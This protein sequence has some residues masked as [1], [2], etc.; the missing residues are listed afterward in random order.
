MPGP[1][2]T[3]PGS[4]TVGQSGHTTD[5]NEIT[6]ALTQASKLFTPWYNVIFYG[7]DPTGSADSTSAFAAAMTA[8]G[9]SP[10]TIYVPAGTYKTSSV[11]SFVLDQNM[12][13]D[14]SSVT[15]INYTGSTNAIVIDNSGTFNDSFNAGKFTGFSL[16]GSTATGTPVG[17]KFGNLQGVVIHDVGIY[18]FAGKGI[19]GLNHSGGWS[20][21]NNIQAILVGNG[22]AA[23][24]DTSS[25]DY[26]NIDLL[27]VTSPGA[28]GMYLQNSA[29]MQGC[30]IRIR[31]NF[32]VASSNTAAVIGIE[33]AGGSGS[34]Y[35]NNCHF[36]VAVENAPADNATIGYVSHYTVYMGSSNAASQLANCTG[37]LSFSNVATDTGSNPINFR[38]YSNVNFLPFGFS[39]VVE[40]TVLGLMSPGDG[41]A[42]VGGTDYALPGFTIANNL[43]A[44]TIF[45]EFGD[46]Q[47]FTLGN[48]NNTITFDGIK[49]GTG[50]FGKQVVLMI[51]QPSSGAAGTVTW[52]ANVKWS[53][54][55]HTLSS[56]NNFVDKV[57]MLY[58]PNDDTW[59]AEVSGLHYS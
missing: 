50:G 45:F 42:I 54:G 2:W 20:E 34:S 41:L 46:I 38:G 7:A 15:T 30:S 6:A 37:V 55:S 25:Y 52:P 5:H 26:S 31:G 28:G 12:I 58:S 56:T 27:I 14:G 32:Y 35:F 43:F 17:I 11:G 51:K 22:T 4:A 49:S 13:G 9:S 39:G 57:R 47:L 44:N 48:G 40:D 24:F 23:V 19:Y 59:Y 53:G 36:D 1:I 3:I 18:A 29:Q 33:L 16:N 8:M 10:G 21:E